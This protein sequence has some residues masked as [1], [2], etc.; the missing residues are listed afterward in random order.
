[1]TRKIILH[2][3]A[4][5]WRD[6]RVRHRAVEAVKD[7]AGYAWEVLDGKDALSAAVAAVKCMEDS[8]VLNAG[9]GSVLDLY[10]TRSL[11]AGVMTSSGLLGAVAGVK[12]TKNPVVLAMLVAA[13]TPHMLLV[14]E[15]ADRYA[16]NRNLPSL[17]PPPEHVVERYHEALKRILGGEARTR[18]GKLLIDYVKA[19]PDVRD[20]LKE[21]AG[22]G[23]TVGAV[24]LDD[25]G[26]LAATVSTGGMLLKLPGRVGDSA[27]PGAGFYANH[28][29]ACSA[30]GWGEEI[31]RTMPCL[32]LADYYRETGGLEEAMDRVME[33]VMET[34]G[35][36]TM[37]FIAVD[38][39]GSIGYRYN[40]EAMLT[41]YVDDDGGVI[42]RL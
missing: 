17:P 21:I 10:G 25:E 9:V 3:G 28:D 35:T 11:D 32:R 26:L 1:M 19:N 6:S 14:G 7:C 8:G 20:R 24:A 29:I 4:G 33:M 15:G 18:Y 13:E 38:R 39:R 12:A 31:I 2:G 37:G 36:D 30:T 27:I 41:A 42:V 40:T 34:V 16:R 22:A 23:D 5:S